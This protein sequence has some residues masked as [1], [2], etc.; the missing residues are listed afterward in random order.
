MIK[1][2]DLYVVVVIFVVCFVFLN[3]EKKVCG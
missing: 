3:M 2:N 1:M